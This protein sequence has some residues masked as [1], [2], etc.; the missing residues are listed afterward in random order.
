MRK[1]ILHNWG[2]KLISL[3]IAVIL[4]FLVVK[5]DDPKD[6]RSFSDIPVTLVNTEL[7]E[8]ENKAY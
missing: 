5:I 3:A 8:Q 2:L 4:W 6:T 7:L 1:K